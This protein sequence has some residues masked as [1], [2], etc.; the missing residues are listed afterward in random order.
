ME[1]KEWIENRIGEL[2]AEEEEIVR[3]IAELKPLE[4]CIEYKWVL[5][6]IGRKYWYFYLRRLE[7]DRLRSIYIGRQIPDEL[8]EAKRDRER[9]R[10]L[11]RKLKSVREQLKI[12][13]KIKAKKEQGRLKARP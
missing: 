6:K 5:N 12:Y 7:G 2:E 4:G 9:L 11:N 13:Y 1:G 10:E 3:E 8:I